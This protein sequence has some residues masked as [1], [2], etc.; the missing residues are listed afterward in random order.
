MEV[1]APAPHFLFTTSLDSPRKSSFSF[2]IGISCYSCPLRSPSFGLITI[3]LMICG[4]L[5]FDQIDEP[6][7]D[8]SDTGP[9]TFGRVVFW[10]GAIA[11]SVLTVAK[12]GEWVGRRLEMEHYHPSWMIMPV[13]LS[14]AALSAVSIPMFNVNLND[15]PDD[16]TKKI[17]AN[18]LVARFFLSFA[19]LMWITLF[20]LGFFKVVTSHNS[21][22]RIR[23]GVFI[24]LAAPCV[25]GLA[26]FAL[27]SA[28][29]ERDDCA[30]DFANY[31]FIGVFLFLSFLW[32]SLPHIGFFGMD[33]FGMGYWTECFALD[34]LAACAAQFYANNGLNASKT[35]MIIALVIAAIANMTAFLHTLVCIIR[36][37]GV[38]T[39]EVKWG[40]LSFM[41][42]T[43][44]AFR[45][46]MATLRGVIDTIDLDS[47]SSDML[48]QNLGLFAAHF[49]RFVIVHEEHA[50]HEDEVIFKIFNDYFNAHAKVYNDDHSEDHRKLEE[51]RVLCNKLLDNDLS[52]A[53]RQEALDV[54]KK[55]LPAFFDHF[56]EHLQGEEDNLNPIGRKILPLEVQK[57]ISREAFRITSAE[58]WEVIIPFIINNLPRHLQRVRYL[59]VLCWSLPERAQFIGAI[60]YRNV[61]AVMWERLRVEVPEIIPRGEANWKRYY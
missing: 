35:L 45:G 51:W 24:W 25:I 54:L 56:L 17:L 20:V 61:D 3:S 32:A 42:L 23:H 22:N 46:N 6:K 5:V 1:S 12:M 10:M 14:V 16:V 60:V 47:K 26:S 44:E 11:H 37:R 59:K 58:R 40:P 28:E 49:N 15:S 50:K 39:P 33:K 19:Y 48:Q 57:Q 7:Y 18:L 13:G 21:D 38:F 30:T 53:V 27:C 34:T 31:Y 4:F 9:Q 8:G 52:N 55:D 43:H 29:G 41:K 36:R 2:T